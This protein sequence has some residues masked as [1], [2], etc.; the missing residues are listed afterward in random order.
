M[1]ETRARYN[2]AMLE[3]V[4]YQMV[5]YDKYMYSRL[6]HITYIKRAGNGKDKETYND[7]IIMADTETSKKQGTEEN[8]VVAFTISIRAYNRNLVTLYG[9]KPSQFI[10][11]LQRILKAM[12]G[13]KTIIYWHNLSYDWVFVRRFMIKAFGEPIKLLA[14][15][16]H[17]PIYIEW[18]NVIFKDS[19]ILAQR[20]LEIWANDLS[21]EHR[22][23]VGK[24]DYDLFRNQDHVFSPDELKYIECDTLAGVECIQ[25]TMDTLHKHIYSMPYTAT[26]IPREEVREIGKKYNA[27]TYF[28]KIALSFEL[29]QIAEK[30]YHGGFTH[31]NRHYV[32]KIIRELVKCYDFASSYPYQLCTM[33]APCEKF[34]KV[35]DCGMA[36]IIVSA[37]EYA[38]MFKLILLKPKL[39]SDK[40]PMPILQSSKAKSINAVIDNGRILCAGY[41]EIYLNEIDLQLI[42]E[43]Y[44]YDLAICTDVWCA[45]KDY[46]PRWFTDYVFKKFAEKT[47]IKPYKATQPVEY[48]LRKSKANCLYGMCVQHPVREDIIEIY[49][50]GKYEVDKKGK[51]AEEKYADYLKNTKNVLPYTWGI[52]CTS[53]A[54]YNLFQ[55]GKCFTDDGMWLYSDTDSIYGYGWDDTKL[56]AFNDAIKQKL[57]D[58]GYGAV[59]VNG[60]EYWLGIAEHDGTADEYIEFRMMGAKRY[61]GR[62]VEDGKLHLT[63][64]GVPKKGVECLNDDINNFNA[65]FIFSGKVTGKKTHKHIF[66][67]D[68]YIDEFGNECGDSIDLTDCD[69]LLDSIDKPNWES[70]FYEEIE[71]QTYD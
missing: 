11:C 51:S 34:Y 66:V 4:P 3:R 64:A 56:Q 46:L 28:K 27:H 48:S 67:D 6:S 39:K 59:V 61:C 30:V 37:D 32:G 18:D 68:I 62:C 47:E 53:G 33:K 12:K 5:F 26:G 20:K 10:D 31:C 19:L 2:Q 23:A 13:Q 42:A 43:S 40:I 15:K 70:I 21:V 22:K 71:V 52:W 9:N 41:V 60:K 45:R 38:Y 55:L 65:G 50:T 17:Y 57:I 69:Y 29:Q 7:V 36:D 24:W 8:I 25:A 35:D 49:E 16:P 54:M 1:R 44:D 63:V 58:R 14:T